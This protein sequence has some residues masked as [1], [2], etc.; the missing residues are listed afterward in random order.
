MTLTA[1]CK[2]CGKPLTLEC[3]DSY[4]ADHDPFK[5]IPLATCN[6]CADY[7]IERRAITFYIKRLCEQLIFRYYTKIESKDLELIKNALRDLLKKYMRCMAYYRLMPVPEWEEA[8]L[9]DMIA[10]PRLFCDVLAQIPG[11]FKQRELV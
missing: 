8:I 4:Q 5:L 2:M 10:K 9:D 1:K 7:R 3:D 6:R 11:M